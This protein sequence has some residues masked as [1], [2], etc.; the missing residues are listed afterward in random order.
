MVVATTH[1][2][3]GVR[4]IRPTRPVRVVRDV[5]RLG[6]GPVRRLVEVE[7]LLLVGDE[8]L[9]LDVHV[10][11]VA[12]GNIPWVSHHE[13]TARRCWVGPV[14]V[15]VARGGAAR[16]GLGPTLVA[17]LVV[18]CLDGNF[19]RVVH[20]LVADWVGLGERRPEGRV[21]DDAA[22]DGDLDRV[23]L[24]GVAGVVLR[25][26][27][28]QVLTR[29]C[30]VGG[31]GRSRSSRNH[32][33]EATEAKHCHDG[34]RCDQC[35][36]PQVRPSLPPAPSRQARG[37]GVCPKEHCPFPSLFCQIV[38]VRLYKPEPLRTLGATILYNYFV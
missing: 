13:T 19:V 7:G 24:V 2:G 14:P 26:I 23:G 17:V 34:E 27:D 38:K 28:V 3:P 30:D 16:E 12:R 20:V 29:R 1:L 22:V 15:E 5:E 33:G 25:E 37:S 18:P 32:S 11:G 10:V 35:S 36:R 31:V 6:S 9:D 4:E 21:L 8:V